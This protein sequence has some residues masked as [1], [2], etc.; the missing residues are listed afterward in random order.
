MPSTRSSGVWCARNQTDCVRSKISAELRR[1]KKFTTEDIVVYV[2]IFQTKP[3][4]NIRIFFS[5]YHGMSPMFEFIA[6]HRPLP[7][8]DLRVWGRS[9]WVFLNAVAYAYPN[10]P[11]DEQKEQMKIFIH[12]LPGV[13]PC[14]RC[15]AHL[16]QEIHRSFHDSVLTSR[17]TLMKWVNETHNSVNRRKHKP[18][19][20]LETMFHLCQTGYQT[21]ALFKFSQSDVK[22]LV[23]IFLLVIIIYL[24]LR[25]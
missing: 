23:I 5:L 8:I 9:C 6:D 19:V 12:S 11:S 14:S 10:E 17:Y 13:L 21:N 22:T 16:L 7:H 20:S 25:R 4:K 24:L 1:I 3:K 15:G 2:I 18:E